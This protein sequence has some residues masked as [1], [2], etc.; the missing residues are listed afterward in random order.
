MRQEV[1]KQAPSSKHLGGVPCPPIAQEGLGKA[2]SQQA[3][4]EATTGGGVD[5]LVAEAEAS[6]SKDPMEKNPPSMEGE[7]LGQ[8][9]N[10]A[11]T[12]LE[13]S[14]QPSTTAIPP[15]TGRAK[16]AHLS[17]P[18]TGYE[19]KASMTDSSIIA[20]HRVLLGTTL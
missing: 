7:K 19:M 8:P 10:S 11:P 14:R 15:M 1:V 16:V 13:P 2:T 5:A 12:G 4:P 6:T 20:E 17:P 18:A 3:P 9:S